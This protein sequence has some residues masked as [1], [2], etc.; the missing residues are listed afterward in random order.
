MINESLKLLKDISVLIV[1][2]DDMSRE[3]LVSGLKPYC[4]NV[5]GAKDGLEG[6]ESFKKYQANIVITDIHMPIMNGLEMM[7]EISK[8]KPYQKFIVFTSFDTDMNL[9]KSIQ[10]GAALFLKKPIDIKELRSMI[11]ALTYEKDQKLT[12]IND[13]ISI[14]L[15]KEKIFKNGEEIYLS[16]LQNKFFWLFAYNLNKLVSYEMIEEF[17]YGNEYVSKGAI[18]NTILRLKRELGIK[19]KNVSETGYI[20]TCD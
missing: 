8:I 7:K 6:I 18:Q 4:N 10:Q 15:E 17:V 2:D 11:I 9:I 13:Q 3:L 5:Y 12:K 20:L 19:L 1:E 14:N 16:Y